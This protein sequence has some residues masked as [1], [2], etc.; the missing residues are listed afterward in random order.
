MMKK[1]VISKSFDHSVHVSSVV[2]IVV[3]YHFGCVYVFITYKYIYTI[4][5]ILM[6]NTHTYSV[7][8]Y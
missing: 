8:I 1:T 2:V 6:K 7:Q 5:A 4:I 3:A